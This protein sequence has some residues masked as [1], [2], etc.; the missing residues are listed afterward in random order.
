MPRVIAVANQKG[1]AGKSTVAVNLAVALGRR[2]VRTLLVDLDPQFD[3]TAML[4]RDPDDAAATIADVLTGEAELPQAVVRDVTPGVDLVSGDMRMAE[5]E[6]SLV[7]Q[8]RREEFL[9]E[10]LVGGAG[11]EAADVVLLDCP[12]N[13]GLLTVNA[14]V[15]AAEV[16][17]PVSMID[18]NAF[19]GATTL[20]RTLETLRRRRVEIELLGV[21]RNCV[22]RRRN[23]Y[24]TLAEALRDLGAPVLET[25]IPMRAAF[26][27]AGTEGVPMVLREPDG[28]SADAFHRLA[29]E[30]A[31][32]RPASAAPSLAE[33]A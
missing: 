26:H 15:A 29:R 13:L 20:L 3:A 18:R 12:P 24:Q 31:A 19:K 2:G 33:V 23:T 22:D 27:D 6:L 17:V 21:L 10:A 32:T 28:L 8:M 16:L 4:G 25:E 5:V 30:I 1:G 9:H 11:G 7:T 14:F